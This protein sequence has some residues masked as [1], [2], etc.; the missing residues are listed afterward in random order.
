[1]DCLPNEIII[2]I[3]EMTDYTNLLI[4]SEINNYLKLEIDKILKKRK[5][6]YGTN[7][8]E[9]FEWDNFSV[10]YLFLTNYRLEFSSYTS[11]RIVYGFPKITIH[12][13]GLKFLNLIGVIT[14]NIPDEIENLK[15]LE[16]FE[17]S[18][19]HIKELPRTIG[20][21]T[22][23]I[24]LKLT[25]NAL[26]NLPD[27]MINLTKLRE[28]ILYRNKL[29]DI[30]ELNENLE[31]LDCSTNQLKIFPNFILKLKLLKHIDISRNQIE[32]LPNKLNSLANL[33]YLNIASNPVKSFPF[34]YFKKLKTLKLTDSLYKKL[35]FL[36]IF[37]L[38]NISCY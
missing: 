16:K 25:D 5:K 26:I 29:K 6:F 15:N 37:Q 38:K 9:L 3:L 10:P 28:L 14:K 2:K 21:L 22:N 24:S 31:I 23:L 35:S 18:D 36:M 19:S 12:L 27:S 8:S 34:Y 30:P 11:N 32:I 20:N 1:M 13:R 7:N 4:I 33:E 17:F